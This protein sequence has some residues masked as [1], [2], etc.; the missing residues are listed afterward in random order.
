MELGVESYAPA[1][2]WVWRGASRM[3]QPASLPCESKNSIC[4]N[5]RMTTLCPDRT[6]QQRVVP[7][8]RRNA[9][10]DNN[11]D[12]AKLTVWRARHND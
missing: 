1:L 10:G 6:P 5:N 2:Q 7:I 8:V 9:R 3:G 11:S 12:V 4:E